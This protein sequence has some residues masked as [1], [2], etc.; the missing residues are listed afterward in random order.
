M[1]LLSLNR[2]KISGKLSILDFS[3]AGHVPTK[4]TL[5]ANINAMLC[6]KIPINPNT[7][8]L[9]KIFEKQI[10]LKETENNIAEILLNKLQDLT[11]NNSRLT[12]AARMA[13]ERVLMDL[14][15]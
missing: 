13:R 15:K 3:M 2:H 12:T 5:R 6:L 7:W 1:R 8:K 9:G 4:V 11:V 10:D 14:R